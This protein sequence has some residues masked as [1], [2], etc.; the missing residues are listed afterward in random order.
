MRF[1]DWLKRRLTFEEP[2]PSGLP[3]VP[4]DPDAAVVRRSQKLLK[5]MTEMNLEA[6]RELRAAA[7]R[8][9][10]MGAAIVDW[11]EGRE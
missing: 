11:W 5:G 4:E 10:S 3:E 7:I 2:A 1:M 9:R 8:E 6:E